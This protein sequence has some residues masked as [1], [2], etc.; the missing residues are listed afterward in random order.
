M[1]TG[2]LV[3]SATANS[4]VQQGIGK[5]KAIMNKEKFTNTNIGKALFF[6]ITAHRGQRRKYTL[7]PYV[8]H[9]IRV[10]QIVSTVDDAPEHAIAAALLHDVLEDTAV[11]ETMMREKFGDAITDLVLEVTDVSTHADGNRA[12]RRAIDRAKLALAS[13]WGA[14][15]KL[16]DL[17]DNSK[18]ILAHDPKFAKVY[19]MEKAQL[20]E[21]MT[22]GDP[23]LRQ[24]A[25]QQA[26]VSRASG[27]I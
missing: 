23:G 6:A 19:L 12:A 11:T 10:A 9:P 4:A 7:E 8:N 15:I 26:L 17:I 22:Q 21:V 27:P 18:D 16:A 25:L 20:L 24:K 14:T 3:E 5:R 13:H 2:P 1:D